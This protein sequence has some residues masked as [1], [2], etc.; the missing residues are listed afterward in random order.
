M[1]N[2]A[3]K[4]DDSTCENP[5]TRVQGYTGNLSGS[6][7]YGDIIGNSIGMQNIYDLIEKVADSESTVVITGESGTGKGMVARAIHNRSSRREKSFITINCGAIPENL[8]ESELFGHVRGAFTGANATKPGKF[9]LAKGGTVFLDEIGDMSTNLQVKILRVLEEREF[10]QVGGSKTFHAD[11]RIIAAT[12]ADLEALVEKGQFREDLFYRLYVV[13]VE[14]PAL[15]DRQS[16]IP[17]LI[18]HFLNQFNKKNSRNVQGL[19]QDALK[20]LQ[21]Y[22]WPGNVRE[23][24]NMMER[25]VVL[26]G[27]GY[28]ESQDLSQKYKKG[29]DNYDISNIKISDDGINL[30]SAV[31]EFEKALILESLN[32]T[33]W[34]K[35]QAAKLLHLNRT[36]LVEKIK[37]HKLESEGP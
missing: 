5:I 15:R 21:M 28:I 7:K 29:D 23:L 36:T 22:P 16:D 10:E 34:I 24:K 3:L 27:E 6:C 18:T 35:N 14:M 17:L 20:A 9:E 33:K 32:R 11:V 37:R 4:T 13:P 2:A 30:N 12:H 8:L 25:M 1:P 19:S 31:T 26:K